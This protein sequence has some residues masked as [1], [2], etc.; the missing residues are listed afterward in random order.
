MK[1]SKQTNKK[2]K[3]MRKTQGGSVMMETMVSLFILAVGLLG[4]LAMQVKGVNSNQRAQFSTEANMLAEDMATRILAYV[5][6]TDVATMG[7][8]ELYDDFNNIDTS[9]SEASQPNCL[10]SGCSAAQ[11]RQYDEFQW[12]NAVK[13]RLPDGLG[14]VSYADGAYQI[15]V[16][17]NNNQIEN[18]TTNCSGALTDLACFTYQLTL[19]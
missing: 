8:P 16:M 3:A 6:N 7:N 11:Q 4:T 10:L 14:K 13:T 2:T 18:P 15:T 12:T 19:E 9:S 5:R 17:W 1:Q